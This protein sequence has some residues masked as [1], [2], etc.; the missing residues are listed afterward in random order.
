[1]YYYDDPNTI[2]SI[3]GK[4]DWKFAR[5]VHVVINKI[6]KVQY[7]KKKSFDYINGSALLIKRE[8]IQE[9]G[10]LDK[11]LFLYFEETDFALK[12]AEKGFKSIYIPKS[13][14]WHKV[15]KSSGGMS[16]SIGLYY[17]TRNRWLFMK[18]WAKKSDY[19]FFVIYQLI[20]A[21]IFP[22]LLSIYYRNSLLFKA[23]YYGLKN[24]IFSE[25]YFS[26]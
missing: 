18:I 25:K 8:V 7:D 4:I 22:L 21:L 9:I 17:I 24:G 19:T 16:K 14:I 12:A 23:Y 2:W 26:E 13:K 15:S 20:G 1:M 6:D 3:G 5:G 11:R 10:F